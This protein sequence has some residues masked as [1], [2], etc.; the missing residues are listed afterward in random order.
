LALENGGW[1]NPVKLNCRVPAVESRRLAPPW[2]GAWSLYFVN[3]KLARWKVPS[4]SWMTSWRQVFP[5]RLLSVF[6]T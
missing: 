6:Q 4:F 2:F 3:L 1:Q 5:Y